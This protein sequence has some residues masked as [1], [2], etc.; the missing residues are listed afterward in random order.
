MEIQKELHNNFSK[1]IHFAN[2]FGKTTGVPIVN[3][4]NTKN[5]YIH[6]EMRNQNT[7]NDFLYIICDGVKVIGYNLKLDKYKCSNEFPLEFAKEIEYASLRYTN[8]VVKSFY[9]DI[10]RFKLASP[11]VYNEQEKAIAIEFFKKR[12]LVN[13]SNNI[14]NKWKKTSIP[15]IEF[16]NK[17]NEI[18]EIIDVEIIKAC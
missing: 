4:H 6:I 15:L 12:N 8:E 1:I 7:F 18:K 9:H 10:K 2:I 13:S 5:E 16:K 3:I 11:K 14:F 17:E